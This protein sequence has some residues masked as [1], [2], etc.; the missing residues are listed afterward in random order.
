[1]TPCEMVH[2]LSIEDPSRLTNTLQL[3]FFFTA[4]FICDILEWRILLCLIISSRSESLNYR[5]NL[6]NYRAVHNVRYLIFYR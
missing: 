5:S 2:S 4:R 3:D 1:M 6:Y